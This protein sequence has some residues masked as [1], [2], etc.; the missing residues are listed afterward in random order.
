MGAT[1]ST[2][3]LAAACKAENG[4]TLYALF[5]QTY[6]QN[7]R[8]HTPS[9]C[10]IAIGTTVDVLRYIF[11]SGAVWVGGLLKV[12]GGRDAPEQYIADWFNELANPVLL[13]N[14]AF[15]LQISDSFYAT[16]PKESAASVL[17]NLQERGY[18]QLAETLRDGGAHIS[19]LYADPEL[20]RIVYSG[21]ILSPWRIIR[22]TPLSAQRTPE[23]GYSPE[24]V[25]A[26]TPKLPAFIKID[27]DN[28]LIQ[29]E[30]RSWA[31]G[32]WEYQ[33]I[34][35]YVQSLWET[36]MHEPGAYRAYIKAYTKAV[37]NAQQIP[38][39][40]TIQVNTQVTLKSK[41]QIDQRDALAQH[42]DGVELTPTPTGYAF[43]VTAAKHVLDRVCRLDQDCITWVCNAEE[44]A[45]AQLLA[46]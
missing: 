39:N 30:D 8:P 29:Q 1:I 9:W 36:Q 23:L 38:A 12:R 37:K 32:G 21:D 4:E 44:P 46:A 13:P 16:I 40:A 2:A 20:A 22:H 33:V 28:R 15:T 6:E 25:K 27:A 14:H 45:Q 11:R 31:L 42:L 43:S 35:N 18:G 3:K 26:C 24:P 34:S 41:W 17:A 19:T 10:C 7:V 5:E